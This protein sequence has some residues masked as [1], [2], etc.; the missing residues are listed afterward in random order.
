VQ[1]VG[2][3]GNQWYGAAAAVPSKYE[4]FSTTGP[5]AGIDTG[6]RQQTPVPPP[7][8]TAP[9]PAAEPAPAPV[10]AAAEYYA[11][12]PPGQPMGFSAPPPQQQ[13]ASSL[14]AA[15]YPVPPTAAVPYGMSPGYNPGH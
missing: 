8:Y 1:Y 2:G 14:V 10:G 15:P 6:Y 11:P 12:A 4:P 13:P 5:N 3:A 9:P 7:P